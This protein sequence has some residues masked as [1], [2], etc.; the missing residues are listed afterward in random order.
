MGMETA[1][2]NLADSWADVLTHHAEWRMAQRNLS[3]DDILLVLDYGERFYRA[4]AIFFYL[5]KCD[6]PDELLREYGRLEGTTV[7]I[8]REM[9]RVL[10]VYRNRQ[11]GLRRVK[12][13]LPRS[14]PPNYLH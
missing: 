2:N 4:G 12:R 5:R 9:P 3:L 8:S 6:I 14:Q 7:V 13:K 10:T 11:K 1:L